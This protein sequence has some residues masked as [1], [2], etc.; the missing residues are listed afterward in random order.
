MNTSGMESEYK[1]LS[2]QYDTHMRRQGI[3]VERLKIVMA[4]KKFTKD[5]LAA[6]SDAMDE[7]SENMFLMA[8]DYAKIAQHYRDLRAVLD[9]NDEVSNK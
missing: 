2:E 9:V 5:N 3:L 6:Y 8:F 1:F 7:M 4:E